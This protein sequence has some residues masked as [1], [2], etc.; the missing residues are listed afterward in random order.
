MELLDLKVAANNEN[1]LTVSG[2][3]DLSVGETIKGIESE[4]L[5]QYKH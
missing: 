2:S 3:Y 4:L 5:Q 1:K